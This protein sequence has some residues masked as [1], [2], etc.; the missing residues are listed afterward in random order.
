MSSM[1]G[2]IKLLP[3]QGACFTTVFYPERRSGLLDSCPYRASL[4]EST[5]K[6]HTH[7]LTNLI[8][9]TSF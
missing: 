5:N 6:Y 3:L 7:N 2:R 9:L 4:N 1:Y 8:I